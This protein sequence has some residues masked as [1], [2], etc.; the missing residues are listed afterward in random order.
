MRGELQNRVREDYMRVE[1]VLDRDPIRRFV[2]RAD[3]TY[4]ECHI[5]I[6]NSTVYGLQS[7]LHW[8]FAGSYME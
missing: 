2:Q 8:I 6:S 7:A 4:F 5:S 3:A 1:E